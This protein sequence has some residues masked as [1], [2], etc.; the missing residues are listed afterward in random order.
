MRTECGPGTRLAVA[1]AF[2]PDARAP[3]RRQRP[4]RT[5]ARAAASCGGVAGAPA[6]GREREG[7]QQWRGGVDGAL[8]PPKPLG[9]RLLGQSA[10]VDVC[11]RLKAPRGGRAR[12]FDWP[13][14][15]SEGMFDVCYLQKVVNFCDRYPPH[16]KAC[17]LPPECP[18][19]A[20]CRAWRPQAPRR[21]GR[22]CRGGAAAQ[23]AGKGGGARLEKR[24]VG[25]STTASGYR[26]VSKGRRREGV[27]D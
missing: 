15:V 27:R 21:K 26:G 16:R 1:G 6:A 10:A 19:P 25:V 18:H 24:G 12:F 5:P 17:R 9:A 22:R 7:R 14:R 11:S 23:E 13:Q 3:P 4:R 8:N 20:P 2:A